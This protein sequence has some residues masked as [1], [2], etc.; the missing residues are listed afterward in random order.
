MIRE[1]SSLVRVCNWTPVAIFTPQIPI[2][3]AIFSFH[4]LPIKENSGVSAAKFSTNVLDWKGSPSPIVIT[5]QPSPV[6]E[7]VVVTGERIATRLEQTAANVVVLTSSELTSHAA[8]T[9]D[10]ALRQTPGFTLFRRS[11]SLTANPTTQGASVRGVGA[12]GASRV[13]VLADGIPLNDAFGGWVYWAA[14]RA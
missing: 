11:N 6:A 12:S 5:L 2:T 9:L 4:L 13:L 7:T 8:V 14:C 3:A 10:D 1:Q